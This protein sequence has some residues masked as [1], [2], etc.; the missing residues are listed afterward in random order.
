[1]S[2]IKTSTY[3]YTALIHSKDLSKTPPN[4]LFP[5]SKS[6]LPFGEQVRAPI[7]VNNK[8]SC[9]NFSMTPWLWLTAR[10]SALVVTLEAVNGVYL[11]C[12]NAPLRL[13]IK[14]FFF[15][16]FWGT[17]FLSG[18]QEAQMTPTDRSRVWAKKS[19]CY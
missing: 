10:I 8:G 11:T 19:W 5:S 15:F 17:L 12:S 16:F 6:P 3:L 13:R 2:H 14:F 9:L 1:M 7:S 18:H 4:L